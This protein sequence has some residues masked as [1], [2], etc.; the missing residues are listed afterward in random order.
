MCRYVGVGGGELEV[1]WLARARARALRLLILRWFGY[2]FWGV[3]GFFIHGWIGVWIYWSA[4]LFGAEFG[5]LRLGW[6]DGT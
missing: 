2:G 1:L 6:M 4:V 3:Y 5:V